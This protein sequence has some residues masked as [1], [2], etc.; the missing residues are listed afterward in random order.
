[1]EIQSSPKRR[2][3]IYKQKLLFYEN[4]FKWLIKKI[5]I[6]NTAL[7]PHHLHHDS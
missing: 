5:L 7:P 6:Q 3:S 1:M 2:D 4:I